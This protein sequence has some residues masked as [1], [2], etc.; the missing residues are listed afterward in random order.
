MATNLQKQIDDLKKRITLIE[1]IILQGNKSV[2]SKRHRQK[3]LSIKEFLIEKNPSND[4]EKTLTIA[5]FIE[6]YMDYPS[7]NIDDLQ[8]G[9]KQAK[10][11]KPANINDKVNMNI[12]KGHLAEAN[13]K[14]DSK[15]AWYVTNSG[16]QLVENNFNNEK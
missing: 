14:K 13:D 15:K 12:K 8:R 6:K 11:K 3:D 7:F 10:E 1:S 5:Y 2:K 9:Y 16:E 4:V